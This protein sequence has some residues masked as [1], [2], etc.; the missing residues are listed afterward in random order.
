LFFE[1]IILLSNSSS[2]PLQ[3]DIYTHYPL[4]TSANT[5]KALNESINS[6]KLK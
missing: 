4:N 1:R 6:F 5:I 2:K 3:Y